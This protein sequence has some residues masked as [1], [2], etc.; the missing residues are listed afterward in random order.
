MFQTT[1]KNRSFENEN[2]NEMGTEDESKE[3]FIK[4]TRKLIESDEN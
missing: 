2:E 3:I 4:M 1:K